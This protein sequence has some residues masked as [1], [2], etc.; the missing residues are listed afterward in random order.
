MASDHDSSGPAPQRLTTTGYKVVSKPSDVSDK[1][2]TTP[3]TTTLV[4]VDSPLLIVHNTP[5]TTPPTT[6]VHAEEE[7]NIQVDDAVFDSYEFI[8]P[9]ATPVMKKLVNHLHVKLICQTCTNSVKDIL[10]NTIGLKTICWNKFM[11][12][13]QSQFRQEY[14]FLLI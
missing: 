12:I 5:D 2:N 7:N 10:L 8:N 11:V 13:L 14:S 9:F 3:S 1:H 6:Q 4:A